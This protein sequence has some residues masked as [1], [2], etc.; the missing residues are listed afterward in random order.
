MIDFSEYSKNFRFKGFA[1]ER[2]ELFV[3]TLHAKGIG[4]DWRPPFQRLE[5]VAASAL[6]YAQERLWIIDQLEPGG[7]T[8]NIPVA[9][10]LK[11]ALD[12]GV[13]ERV[14]KEVVKRHEVLRT[15]IEMREGRGVQV[16]E[17]GWSG[18]VELVDLREKGEEGAVIAGAGA[19]VR[20][21]GA[22]SACDDAPHRE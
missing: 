8:Y 7:A 1:P 19:E 9:V 4:G 20:G 5:R 14:F 6:S 11:G 16:I 18:A 2:L 15:R 12:V 13:V 21:R 17:G 3:R 22:R 10:R